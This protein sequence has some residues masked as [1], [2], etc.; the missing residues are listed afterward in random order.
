MPG[1]DWKTLQ[2]RKLVTEPP[3]SLLERAA[4]R[5][6]PVPGHGHYE[7][8]DQ[9]RVRSNKY[10]E[11]RLLKPRSTAKGGYLLVKLRESGHARDFRVHKLV[12]LTFVGPRPDGLEICHYDGD[13][14]NNALSNLR[15]DTSVA[16]AR[17]KARHGT[18]HQLAKSHCPQ[19][20]PYD[21]ANT[22][23]DQRGYRY[24]RAC[25]RA[26]VKGR[27]DNDRRVLRRIREMHE[28]YQS[29]RLSPVEWAQLVGDLLREQ[30]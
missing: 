2:R 8:S 15:Y 19:G 3:S 23:V 11:P 4:E 26:K 13:P 16:N 5:W 17:D 29:G 25:S 6:L 24:C 30:P 14:T 12:M 10:R 21:E 18:H 9:G 22:R 1:I 7:V 28:D 27:R 20:H